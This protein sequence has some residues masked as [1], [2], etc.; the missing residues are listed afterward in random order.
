M[1]AFGDATYET[2]LSVLTELH[3]QAS[4]DTSHVELSAV[5]LLFALYALVF[6]PPLNRRTDLHPL[7]GNTCRGRCFMG[8]SLGGGAAI[9]DAKDT[10]SQQATARAAMAGHLA[11]RDPAAKRSEGSSCEA[12]ASLTLAGDPR[13]SS[14]QGRVSDQWS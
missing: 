2:Q 6:A 9:R 8:R 11:R 5:S 1:R 10:A 12:L 3:L 7:V 4:D 14:V 13:E